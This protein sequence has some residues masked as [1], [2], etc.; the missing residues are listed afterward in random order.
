MAPTPGPVAGQAKA[1]AEAR[2]RLSLAEIRAAMPF[3]VT[4]YQATGDG[5]TD[6]TTF[7][8]DAIDAVVTA[9]GG[10]LY[11]PPGTY[12]ISS[13]LTY[14]SNQR[15]EFAAGASI[16]LMDS[17]VA[18]LVHTLSSET[19]AGMV[20]PSAY[21]GISNVRFV[22][23]TLDGNKANN[24]SSN[25]GDG[26]VLKGAVSQV[27]V[28]DYTGTNL[29]REGI[30][31]VESSSGTNKPSNVRL[32]NLTLSGCGQGTVNGGNG[33]GLTAGSDISIDG[34]TIS[35]S[36]GS[37][38]HGIDVEPN[39]AVAAIINNVRI[40]NG[41]VS[42]CKTVGLNITSSNIANAVRDISVSNVRS[43]T[44][45]YGFKL[46]AGTLGNTRDIKYINCRAYRNTSGGFT[47]TTLDR[48]RLIACDAVENTGNG[49]TVHQQNTVLLGCTAIDDRGGSATQD[50]GFAE[51]VG[52]DNN[53]FIGC[54]TNGNVTAAYSLR[55]VSTIV[56]DLDTGQLKLKSST[57]AGRPTVP[58]TNLAGWGQYDS[59]IGKPIW[60]NGSV[61]K[62]AA[63]NTV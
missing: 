32:R 20:V 5:V 25:S 16:K 49:F 59:T 31:I 37:A 51:G 4:D 34:F 53:A 36:L 14:G 46:N 54:K 11:F 44:N 18:N 26:L 19:L 9:G 38:G 21:T 47:I 28:D 12:L 60:W 6:D 3:V 62:D 30:A 55:G 43:D 41:T 2:V 13:Y 61:W 27:I 52:A 58:Q 63:G 48:V 24:S 15:W 22:N 17:S 23:M 40:A 8:Q 39:V 10:T 29:P 50:I 7:I 56:W 1:T 42:G 45:A 35:G 57:T 33:I